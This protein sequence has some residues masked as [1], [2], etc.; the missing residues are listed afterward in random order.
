MKLDQ[1]VCVYK[2]SHK[3]ENGSSRVKIR[4]LGQIL[5]KLCVRSRGHVFSPIIM[6]LG[7]NVCLDKISD[8][9]ETWSGHVKN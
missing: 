2:I 1:H 3:S 7:K 9:F 6:E 4:S 5:G 8:E